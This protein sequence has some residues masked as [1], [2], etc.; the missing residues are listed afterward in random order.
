MIDQAPRR[1]LLVDDDERARRMR[2]MTLAT[3]GYEVDSI[4]G[5]RELH[6]GWEQ[7]RYGLVLLSMSASMRGEQSSWNRIQR[8]HPAQGFMFLLG[9][10]ARLCPLF[11]DGAQVRDEERSDAFLQRVQSAFPSLTLKPNCAARG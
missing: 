7:A 2:A 8:E 11:L 4:S 5:L 1:I 6:Y 3:H 9:A 10:S